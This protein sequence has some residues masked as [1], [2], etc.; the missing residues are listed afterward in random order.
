[1]RYSSQFVEVR[2]RATLVLAVNILQ[3]QP[4]L[5]GSPAK[6]IAPMAVYK[7]MHYSFSNFI[8]HAHKNQ[9]Q[10]HAFC[11]WDNGLPNFTDLFAKGLRAGDR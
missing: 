6:A 4:T 1:V 8:T 2:G 9:T 3:A 11:G 7:A 5:L 10:R